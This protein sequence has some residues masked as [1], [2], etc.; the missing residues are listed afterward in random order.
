MRVNSFPQIQISVSCLVVINHRTLAASIQKHKIW[1]IMKC[2]LIILSPPPPTTS[3]P[4]LPQQLLSD[5]DA[6]L[7]NSVTNILNS[8]HLYYSA[9]YPLHHSIQHNCDNAR[10]TDDR[11]H[12]NKHLTEEW[13]RK[14]AG[15]NLNGLCL[16]VILGFAGQV[17]LRMGGDKDT[18][19]ENHMFYLETMAYVTKSTSCYHFLSPAHK[20]SCF[21][22][23]YFHQTPWYPIP[24]SRS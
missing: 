23:S 24:A 20:S 21:N 22:F 18:G 1:R 9:T 14:D 11:Y 6:E 8:T 3:P 17:D 7:F 16:Y 4:T 12:F 5:L 15:K 13:S 2:E 10:K 19:I